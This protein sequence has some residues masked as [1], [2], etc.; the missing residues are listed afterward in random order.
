VIDVFDLAGA[1]PAM[2][3]LRPTDS[4]PGIGDK[5]VGDFW[6]WAYSNLIVNTTRS[7][8]AEYLVATSLG[9]NGA[10]RQEWTTYDF[11]YRETTIEVKTSGYLQGWSQNKLSTIVFDI[12][13]RFNR[14]E[15]GNNAVTRLEEAKR[16]A[17][18]YVFCIHMA[19]HR[20]DAEGGDRGVA[21]LMSAQNWKFYVVPT[22]L[23][24]HFFGKQ[25]QVRLSVLEWSLQQHGYAAITY[26]QLKCTIDKCVQQVCRSDPQ[27]RRP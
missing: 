15:P 5:T 27:I 1:C 14:W 18:L 19:Q 17:S 9:L 20:D 3:L 12:A 26:E 23:I 21:L 13:P 25:K 10:P 16:L 2:V 7:I 24:N 4:I 22:F 11:K 6:S 8:F